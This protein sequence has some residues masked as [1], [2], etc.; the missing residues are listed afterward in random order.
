[1]ATFYVSEKASDSMNHDLIINCLLKSGVYGR[2]IPLKYRFL[3]TRNACIKLNQ[4]WGDFFCFIL[5]CTLSCVPFF[6]TNHYIPIPFSTETMKQNLNLLTIVWAYFLSL[7][8]SR[9]KNSRRVSRNLEI[10][11]KQYQQWANAFQYCWKFGYSSNYGYC[12]SSWC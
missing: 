5:W 8:P 6:I 12:R 11:L 4:S 10:G 3:K 9:N 2:N 1:M 7:N